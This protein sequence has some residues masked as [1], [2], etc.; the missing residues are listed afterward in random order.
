MTTRTCPRD[1]AALLV[2]DENDQ[3]QITMSPRGRD[4]TT[5]WITAEIAI[6]LGDA[7]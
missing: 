6:Q 5:E 2:H 4:T 1:R 7:R 3:G